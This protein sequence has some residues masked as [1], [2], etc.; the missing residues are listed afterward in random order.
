MAPPVLSSLF[1]FG[2]DVLST[3]ID[4]AT[5]A[6]SAQIGDV[7]AGVA[8]AS[9][10][11][12]WQHVGFASRPAKGVLGQ[13]ASQCIAITR[14]DRN[15]IIATRDARGFAIYGNLKD[16]ETCVYAPASMARTFYKADGSVTHYTTAD[17]TP[18]GE[19]IY[20]RMA[21]DGFSWKAPW[22]TL[23]WDAQG[24]RATD[25]SGAKLILAPAGSPGAPLSVVKSVAYISADSTTI[26]WNACGK[27]GLKGGTYVQC[28]TVPTGIAN[29]ISGCAPSL[30]VSIS[31]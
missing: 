30:S 6:I 8:E 19:A 15:A 9:E 7:S 25:A 28:A 4:T 10:D 2:Y 29:P 26:E 20:W 13:G 5:N 1:K 31:V 22:G 23:I 17:N 27:I 12:W 14:S 11:E 24:L 18:E 21:R 16:G 3:A